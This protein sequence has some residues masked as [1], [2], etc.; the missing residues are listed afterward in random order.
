MYRKLKSS[1]NETTILSLGTVVGN[2]KHI[3]SLDEDDDSDE[4]DNDETIPRSLTTR[5]NGAVRGCTVILLP[6]TWE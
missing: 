4:D 3:C 6:H 5:D 2:Y 1:P